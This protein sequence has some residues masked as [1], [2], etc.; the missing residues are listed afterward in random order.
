MDKKG[1]HEKCAHVSF[2]TLCI[3]GHQEPEEPNY[4]VVY[5]IYQTVNFAFKNVEHAKMIM[6][7]GSLFDHDKKGLYIYSRGANP[8]TRALELLAADLERTEDGVA[9]ASGMSAITSTILAFVEKG[10]TVYTCDT[11]YGETFEFFSKHLP[12]YGVKVEFVDMKDPEN[13]QRSIEKSGKPKIIYMETPANPTLKV[14]PIKPIADIAH[15]YEAKLVVDNTFATPYFQNP[16]ELGA[17]IVVH[18]ATKYL[19]GHSDVLGGLA[20]GTFEDMAK[21]RQNLYTLGGVLDPFAAWLILRGI[22][23]LHL[24]MEKHFENALNIAE[25]LEQKGFKVYYPYLE[26]SEYYDLAVKQMK[27]FSGLISFDVGSY[28]K[29]VKIVEKTKIFTKAVSLGGVESL[30]NHPASTTHYHI[31]KEIRENRGITDGLIRLSVGI[32][33]VRDL[34]GDLEN[35]IA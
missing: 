18:S 20:V 6:S 17:A 3:H 19:G 13:L 33:N 21:I 28:E 32:E 22:K 25:F 4:P 30:I 24:R 1:V 23:T 9:F 12:K 31:P 14:Y 35:A 34:I 11:M 27:G 10:D 8:T 2:E 7:E 15:E 26:S 5:P 29:A 16:I